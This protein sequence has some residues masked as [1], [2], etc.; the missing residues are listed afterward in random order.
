MNEDLLL[1][2]EGAVA[3]V[4]I[5]REKTLN[6]LNQDIIIS[7][8]QIIDELEKD[9]EIIV[10][11]IT[12]AGKKA[13]VAGA[14]IVE[15][16]NAGKNRSEMIRR[17]QKVFSKIRNSTKI[18]IAAINGY[19]LGGGLELALACDI[20]IA[21]ENARFGLPETR[22]G[23]MPGYGGTQLLARLVGTGRAKYMIFSGESI[24]A[25]E[26]YQFGLVE[27]V[28]EE[29][30]LMEEAK[31][32]AKRI[33]QN[34][35]FALKACKKAINQGI[36]LTIDDALML[37]LEEYDRVSKSEDAEEGIFA[38]LEKRNPSFKGK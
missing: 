16:K 7:L 18:I 6:A 21:S 12:G 31:K 4:T 37:E 8:E 28:V 24:T 20:R 27:M 3:Y 29:E 2:K 33:S 23:L 1:R 9:D 13:F 5:N 36:E 10:I 22:L 17:N 38:F 26:A 34:G 30:Y 35:P 32:L 15:I 14:D 25:N 11:V 19:A